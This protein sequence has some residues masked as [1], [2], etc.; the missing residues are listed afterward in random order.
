MLLLCVKHMNLGNSQFKDA[1]LHIPTRLKCF[2]L[3][4]SRTGVKWFLTAA[5]TAERITLIAF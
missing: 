1:F 2:N 3:W 4:L 5:P